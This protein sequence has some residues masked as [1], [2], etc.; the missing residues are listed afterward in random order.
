MNDITFRRTQLPSGLVVLSEAMPDRRT[1]AAGA[2]VRHGA[3]DDPSE[4]LGI[5][6]FIEHM[7]FKGTTSRD[8]RMLAASLESL[9]GHL[10]ASTAREQ[11]CYYARALA[12]HL[13]E[14][15]EVLGD[16]VTRPRFAPEDIEREKDVVREEISEC[17]DDPEDRVSE[18][19][20]QRLW[21]G[22][23]L[24]LPILG[25]RESVGALDRDALRAFHAGRYRAGDLVVTA[26]GALEHDRLVDLCQRH[27]EPPAG[28]AVPG[29]GSPPGF[30]PAV[31]HEGRR[32][33]QQVYLALGTRGLPW[34]HPGRFPLL[35]LVTLLG[36]GMSSRLFQSVREEAGLAY[37]IDA[38]CGFHRDAGIV[39]IHLGVA[40]DRVSEALARV[41]AEL[42]RLR[43]EG[44]GEDEVAS[45]K[46]QIRGGIVMS[47]ESVSSR[48]SHLAH[49]ELLAGR[50]VTGEEQ[51][52]EVL[53]VT[54]EQVAGWARDLL[55]PERFALAAVGPSAAVE[56]DARHWPVAG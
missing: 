25:T 13:P 8:A 9:G 49:E 27:F 55:S 1:L 33:L 37:T 2:W 7:A 24:G 18:I 42:E 52:R 50:Y 14:T 35:V 48:M 41:R 3:R 6:H 15:I 16:L 17:E 39:S 34:V 38:A 45:A 4:R 26:A 31:D 46:A 12:E 5:S 40:P 43:D 36:G 51:V 32:D 28:E 53:A 19:L 56:L 10:D 29:N 23:G 11:T 54:R 21:G 44:P 22:H 47:Q 20:V 30:V